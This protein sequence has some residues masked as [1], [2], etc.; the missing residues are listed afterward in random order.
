MISTG[1]SRKE[2]WR[3]SSRGRRRGSGASQADRK[4]LTYL[5]IIAVKY[6]VDPSELLG[7]V[8]EAWNQEESK[9]KQM[10]VK[11]R[12]KTEDS[13]VFLFTVGQKVVAQLPVPNTVLQGK[14]QLENYAR[15]IS[16][17]ASTVVNPRIEDLRAGMKNVNL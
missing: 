17:R 2:F 12:Q 14:Y 4:A 7:Q 8:K 1:D 16:K 13:A 10:T 9:S 3:Q 6:E 5:A 11:C 15:M